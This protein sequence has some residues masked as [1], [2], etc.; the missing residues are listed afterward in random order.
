MRNKHQASL[1][2]KAARKHLTAQLAP[3]TDTPSLD[4]QVLLA[5]HLSA[6]RS[7]L[8]AHPEATLTPDQEGAL[9]TSLARLL[10]GELLPYLL[11]HWEFYGLDFMVS[12]SALIPRPETELLVEQALAW[13]RQRPQ[14]RLVADVGTGCGCIAV[15]LA[16]HLPGLR[17]IASDLSSAA[18]ELARANSRKLVVEQ[19][20]SFVRCDLLAPFDKF[21]L[22]A[23]NLPYIPSAELESLP[24][25]R[26]EPRLA[27]DGGPD[28]LET[29]H[30]LLHQTLTRLAAGGLL[31]LEIEGSQGSAA[32]ALA[33][34]AFPHTQVQLLADLAGQD[35]L[36][37]LEN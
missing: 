21:D 33:Q 17:V 23:A 18:L 29:I 27:L 14:R 11:G 6:P 1:T 13:L 36:I 24:V 4:A 35:R 20:I 31:L 30:R 26:R 37:R 28:G 25:A 3:L 10:D 8:L 34:A 22:I 5:H 2:I 12:P 32:L 19:R 7:W 16:T 9:Q 15:T